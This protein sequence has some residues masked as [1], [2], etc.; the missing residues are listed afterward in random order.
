M[1]FNDHIDLDPTLFHEIEDKYVCADCL[2]DEGL[3]LFV[4]ERCPPS[5]NA[6]S[7]CASAAKTVPVRDFQSHVLKF[8]PYVSIEQV[9]PRNDG[10]WLLPGK[11]GEECLEEMLLHAVSDDLYTELEENVVDALYCEHDWQSLPLTDQWKGQW[12]E[13]SAHVRYQDGCFGF[14]EGVINRER[15]H[16]ERHPLDFFNAISVALLRVDGFSL[17]PEGHVIHRVRPGDDFELVFKELTCPP[18]RYAATNRFSPQ[19]VSRFYGASALETACLEI[20]VPSGSQISA[21]EFRT[22]RPLALIDFTAVQFPKGKFDPS[23]IANYHIA[24]FLKGFLADIRKDV[25]GDT[26]DST[27]RPTQALCDFF[28]ARGATHLCDVNMWDPQP[29]PVM[30]HIN[31]TGKIDGIRFHSAKVDTGVSDCFVL[32]CNQEESSSMV[33]LVSSTR[34]TVP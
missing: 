27:Y 8:F 21:G 1:G 19:G 16:D 25:K 23:W 7:Y 30:Q 17:L 12:N 29:S 31:R 10:E 2:Y 15:N 14:D 3:K 5:G 24:E 18:D 11:S 6:C 33:E 4:I 20:K 26:P 13:F 34:I 28:S 9:M 22:I 32:F